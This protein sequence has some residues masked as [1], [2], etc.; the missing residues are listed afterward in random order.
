VVVVKQDT[1]GHLVQTFSLLFA[2][3]ASLLLPSP[4]MFLFLNVDPVSPV[5]SSVGDILCDDIHHGLLQDEI[6]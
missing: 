3:V 1:Q 6:Q 2:I 5:V 4:P